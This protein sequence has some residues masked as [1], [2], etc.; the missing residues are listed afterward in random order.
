MASGALIAAAERHAPALP[1]R[2]HIATTGADVAAS[3]QVTTDSRWH[4]R[5]ER[6][7]RCDRSANP[8]SPPASSRAIHA[9]TVSRCTPNF[10]ATSVT[11]IPSRTTATTAS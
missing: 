1:T 9:Y 7:G 6:S 11:A 4:L 8:S 5:R 2:D 3:V 10:S